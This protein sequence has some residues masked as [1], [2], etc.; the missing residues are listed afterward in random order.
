M[1]P[2]PRVEREVSRAAQTGVL[3]VPNMSMSSVPRSVPQCLPLTILD[4]SSNG[5]TTLPESLCT[6]PCLQELHVN[7][8]ELSALPENIG[9]LKNLK[10]LACGFNQLRS[11]PE[12]ICNLPR[13]ETLLVNDNSLIDLPTRIGRVLSLREI[14]VQYNQITELPQSIGQLE[15][16]REFNLRGNPLQNPSLTVVMEG[17]KAIVAQMKTTVT[18][19][20]LADEHAPPRNE[21]RTRLSPARAV[22]E[23]S[24]R[25]SIDAEQAETS[26]LND[27]TANC[28]T[29]GAQHTRVFG[30]IR[31]HV[32]TQEPCND[33]PHQ[34]FRQVS[35]GAFCSE[36]PTTLS[37]QGRSTAFSPDSPSASQG[38]TTRRGTAPAPPSHASETSPPAQAIRSPSRS[39]ARATQSVPGDSIRRLADP[40]RRIRHLHWPRRSSSENSADEETGVVLTN[41]LLGRNPALLQDLHDLN[42]VGDEHNQAPEAEET[43]CPSTEK[44]A[45]KVPDSANAP[46]AFLCPILH[47][48]MADPVLAA[49]GH[50]YERAAIGRWFHKS[51]ASPMTGQRVKSREVLP[52]FTIKSMI[53]EWIDSEKSEAG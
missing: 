8:C 9:C 19:A 4:M 53:Q 6:L 38:A 28:P 47:E 18:P 10:I 49:D 7:W 31:P 30:A 44:P 41:V 3:M 20:Q 48:V 34:L 12:S 27:S 15:S 32:A 43:K 51:N 16:L 35:G 50:T 36:N 40:N 37:I 39:P 5:L 29:I 23:C 13:L 11:L 1:Q 45:I 52:N 26:R 2:D 14:A 22:S 33:Q 46:K 25:L 21:A 17:A 42:I 24:N